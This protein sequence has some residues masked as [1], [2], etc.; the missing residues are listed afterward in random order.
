MDVKLKMLCAQAV[1]PT[2]AH[3]GDAGLD[4]TAVNYQYDNNTQNHI[5]GVG[6]A[7]EI[8][9]GYVGLIFPR[10]S[11]RRTEAFMT[12]HVSVID[13]G[14]RGEIYLTF[15]N[16]DRTYSEAPYALGERIGQLVIIP[17]PEI[18]LVVSETLSPSSRGTNGHGSSGK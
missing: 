5:Y 13:S 14:Y 8:P 4:L 15:K 16:R 9:K 2:Y 6:F 3:E 1:I 17:Y 7:L 11:N 10:S 12:N 18:N